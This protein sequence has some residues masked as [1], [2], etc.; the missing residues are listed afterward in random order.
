MSNQF[1]QGITGEELNVAAKAPDARLIIVA[2]GLWE[3]QRS[4]F[5]DVRVC[6]P[7][8]D[9]CGDMDPDQTF[10][11]QE[12]EKKRQYASTVLGVE[13]A[14]FTPLVFSTKG[15]MAVECK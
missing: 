13:Q 9:S 7:N 6:Y 5:F 8:A 2:R 4:V 15:G 11:Q 1:L 12:T 3:E 14:T 10:R